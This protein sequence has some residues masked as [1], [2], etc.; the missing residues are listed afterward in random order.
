MDFKKLSTHDVFLIVVFVIYLIFN[1]QAPSVVCASMDNVVGFIVIAAIAIYILLKSN[2]IVGVLALLVAYQF[3][4]RC[5][6]KNSPLKNLPFK[7]NNG[8]NSPFKNAPI[9]LEEEMVNKMAPL[10]INNDGPNTNVK[11]IVAE[12]HGAKYLN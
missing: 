4:K 11:P 9:T 1:I 3:I 5:N 8:F 2:P 12:Q 6:F 7:S 10:V